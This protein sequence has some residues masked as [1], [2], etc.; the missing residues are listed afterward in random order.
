MRKLKFAGFFEIN[1]SV[2]ISL[3]IFGGFGTALLLFLRAT[4]WVHGSV[5]AAKIIH[6]NL[7]KAILRSTNIGIELLI[8]FERAPMSFFNSTPLGRIMNRFSKGKMVSFCGSPCGRP[9]CCRR[10]HSRS[11]FWFVKA[12]KLIATKYIFK[13]LQAL[14]CLGGIDSSCNHQSLLS[15]CVASN[16]YFL[17]RCITIF[18]QLLP[19][20]LLKSTIASLAPKFNDYNP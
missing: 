14:S 1:D 4:L 2:Y 11:L 15:D 13:W 18:W 6:E 19:T 8:I 5:R 16:W 9:I 7:M 20:F 17:L 10:G 12:R 3:Y